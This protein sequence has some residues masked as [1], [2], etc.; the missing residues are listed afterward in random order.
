MGGPVTV[1]SSRAEL[2]VV[3]TGYR[4]IGD[5]TLEAKASIEQADTVLCLVG[6]PMVT[7]Y[8]ERLNPSVRT[9]D[10]CYAK[11]KW[12]QESYEEMVQILNW[13]LPQ[14]KIKLHRARRAFAARYARQQE[15]SEEG[16]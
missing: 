11:G 4:A 6:D 3:G 16:R 14:V 12:R 7:G 5:L 2:V 9:L 1:T 15:A 10:G 8:L 13:T